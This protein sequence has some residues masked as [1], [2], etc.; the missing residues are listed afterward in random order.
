MALEMKYFVLK[1]ISN[2]KND[3]YAHASRMAMI[4]YASQ[5]FD[6]DP[7]LADGLTKWADKATNDS[8]KFVDDKL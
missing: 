6:T 3:A 1:P 2:K 7:V 8:T 5:I 4:T